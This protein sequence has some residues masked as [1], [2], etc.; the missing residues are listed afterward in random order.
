MTNKEDRKQ[1]CKVCGCTEDKACK[2]GCEWVR[3]D[4]CSGCLEKERLVKVVEGMVLV[5]QDD[6]SFANDNLT[7][8]P[9]LHRYANGYNSALSAVIEAIKKRGINNL[10]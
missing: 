6:G 7:V 4:L 2:G 1:K 5:S 8:A 3:F 10:T 9:D